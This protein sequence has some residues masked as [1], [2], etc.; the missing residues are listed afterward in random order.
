MFLGPGR[1][2]ATHAVSTGGA[3][4]RR[5]VNC[6]AAVTAHPTLLAAAGHLGTVT[7]R[8]TPLASP[9][10]ATHAHR[11]GGRQRDCGTAGGCRFLCRAHDRACPRH[12]LAQV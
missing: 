6:Y 7:A 3:R 11:E 8:P 1:P 9:R 4:G 10:T 2:C 12:R 5:A